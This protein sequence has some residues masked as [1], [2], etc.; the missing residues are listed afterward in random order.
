[1]NRL[2]SS[3]RLLRTLSITAV[4]SVALSPVSNWVYKSLELRHLEDKTMG[5]MIVASILELDW[6]SLP[7]VSVY[8]G[9]AA[10]A[11]ALSCL[12]QDRLLTLRV[13]VVRI[14]PLLSV[15]AWPLLFLPSTSETTLMGR[16]LTGDLALM[17]LLTG[18]FV[19]I[20]RIPAIGL[21]TGPLGAVALTDHTRMAR[22]YESM[23]LSLLLF[24]LLIPCI[25]TNPKHTL[26]E[27]FATGNLREVYAFVQVMGSALVL[28]LR[29]TPLI[30]RRRF[31]A[32]LLSVLF[33]AGL[34]N[35][36]IAASWALIL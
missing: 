23:P 13:A 31:A 14:T 2:V 1:M 32:D 27:L 36:N 3:V 25:Y 8:L 28:C 4:I 6:L 35:H 24:L 22:T 33:F 34:V 5:S 9:T 18:Y 11:A 12:S 10:I 16:V 26:T 29:F 20:G 21:F 19:A 7:V 17:V 30:H 15:C